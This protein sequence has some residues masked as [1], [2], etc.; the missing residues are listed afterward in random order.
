MLN[1]FCPTPNK[2]KT[3]IYP[4][5][6]PLIDTMDDFPEFM[7]SADNSISP[8]LQSKG[9]EGWIYEGHDGK[10]MAYWICHKDVDSHE[11]RHDFEEYFLVVEG[12]FVMKMDGEEH[13]L[14]KGD[15]FFIPAGM[16]HSGWA[17]KGTR[18]IH[19]FGGK[20]A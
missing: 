1:I 4:N 11:H 12:K 3:L 10:Q 9:A 14:G 20:R 7:K 8:F 17:K 18:T 5:I 16:I 13:T 19:C 2:H 15:E 6:T